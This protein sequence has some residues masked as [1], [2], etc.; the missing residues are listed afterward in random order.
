MVRVEN[1]QRK[2]RRRSDRQK[3]AKS[4]INWDEVDGEKEGAGIGLPGTR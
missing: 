3:R 2:Y 1:Q 4:E